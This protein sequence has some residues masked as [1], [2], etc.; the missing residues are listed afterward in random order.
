MGLGFM[1]IKLSP[2]V[3]LFKK[4]ISSLTMRVKVWSFVCSVKLVYDWIKD[5]GFRLCLD[6]LKQVSLK[7]VA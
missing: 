1:F 4:L 2:F 7:W 6:D 3:L 5:D